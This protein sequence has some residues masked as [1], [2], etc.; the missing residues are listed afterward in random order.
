MIFVEKVIHKYKNT[1]LE[2]TDVQLYIRRKWQ[3]INQI[4]IILQ[5]AKDWVENNLDICGNATKLP[6]EDVSIN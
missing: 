3:K 2:R 4:F 5:V 6:R 1:S